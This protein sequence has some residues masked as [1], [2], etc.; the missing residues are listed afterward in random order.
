MRQSRLPAGKENL[1]QQIKAVSAAAQARGVELIK[2][3]IGQPKG[4][5]FLSAR[6]AAAHAIMSGEESQHEYQDNTCV[7]I[8]DFAQRFV[9]G[10]LYSTTTLGDGVGYLPIPGIKPM[11]SMVILACGSSLETVA[12]T[13][14][15]GY[16]T[17][18]D[19][20]GYLSKRVIEPELNSGNG[21]LFNPDDLPGGVGLIMINYPHNPSGAV[22]TREWM[23]KLCQYCVDMDIRLFNDAAYA[24]VN[25][26]VTGCLLSEVAIN[27]PELSW[28]EAFS[29]SKLIG[30]GTG[31]RVGA[32]DGS[33]DFVADIKVIK[34]NTDSGF[35][36]P[37]AAGALHTLEHDHGSI[38]RVVQL[39]QHRAELLHEILCGEGMIPALV[40][41][42]TFFTLWHAPKRVFGQAVDSAVDFNLA[43]IEGDGKLGLVGVPF[44][45][46]I[47]YAVAYPD[48]D[49]LADKTRAVFAKAKVSY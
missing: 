16:P 37:M 47:R 8:P 12:M 46:Y 49:E 25:Y 1:F 24:A 45:N 3:S 31:W 7:P 38:D 33:P 36:A 2:Y 14:N 30:N 4:S 21:F 48:V 20:C 27:F 42:A 28:A 23:E 44:G 43:M 18:R 26:G 5:A 40:P 32:L 41:E 6:E 22:A 11:L 17:P 19:Q 29:A 15:P 13:T 9:E 39:Y 35:V 34:G 10:H